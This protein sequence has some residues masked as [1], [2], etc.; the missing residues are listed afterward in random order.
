MR[1]LLLA[2]LALPA[3]FSTPD[4]LERFWGEEHGRSGGLRSDQLR[5]RLQEFTFQF[6]AAVRH[7]ALAMSDRNPDVELRRNTILWRSTM[8]PAVRIAASHENPVEAFIDTWTLCVQQENHLEGPD[9]K[10]LF[11]DQW[12]AAYATAAALEDDVEHIGAA[13]MTAEDLQRAKEDVY[14]F[15][16]ETPLS[17]GWGRQGTLPSGTDDEELEWIIGN[18]LSAV[19][20]FGG[21]DSTAQA[22]RE[23]NQVAEDFKTLAQHLPEELGWRLDLLLLDAA[24]H[25]RIDDLAESV[26]GVSEAT[27]RISAVAEA[28]PEETR[29]TLTH[30]FEELEQQYAPVQA[31]LEESRGVA[32]ES[33]ATMSATRDAMLELNAAIESTQVL[34]AAVDGLLD[35][36]V[37]VKEEWEP[38]LELFETDEDA[39]DAAPVDEEGPSFL[40]EVDIAAQ[41]LREA[42]VEVRGVL[43]DVDAIGV[44]DEGSA[45]VM[46]AT[47][48]SR[49]TIDHATW[50]AIQLVLVIFGAALV[51]QFVKRR[52]NPTG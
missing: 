42:A 8:I 38:V 2:V 49:A 39:Q 50:R 15:S 12:E 11:G 40:E 9:G 52:V 28:L 45:V 24:Q 34:V 1:V 25:A 16:L 22:V 43:A 3:C 44:A 46:A 4:P 10:R 31:M 5:A 41:S 27:V 29:A 13:F 47:D 37:V 18:P 30:A 33:H 14:E 19:N 7:T 26:A 23:F 6:S 20:P 21:L 51:Y 35:K 36:T 17:T 48:A 32:E